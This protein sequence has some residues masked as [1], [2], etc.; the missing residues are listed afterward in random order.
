MSIEV[1]ECRFAL[2]TIDFTKFFYAEEAGEKYAETWTRC[3]SSSTVRLAKVSWTSSTHF[4]P[5]NASSSSCS[6]WQYR[7]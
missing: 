4:A 2:V 5:Q 3:R 6:R 7:S 1:H